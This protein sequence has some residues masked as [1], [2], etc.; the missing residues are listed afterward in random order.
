MAL[1]ELVT[2]LRYE[3]REGNL[4]KYVDGY[5]RAEG[6]INSAA[7]AATTKLNT[8]LN[9]SV[10]ATGRLERGTGRAS[11]AIGRMASKARQFGRDLGEGV[12]KGSR[13]ASAALDKLE[14]RASKLNGK[15]AG[16]AAATTLAAYAVLVR[17]TQNAARFNRENQL[18]GNTAEMNPAE[19]ASLRDTILNEARST[20]QN[21]DDLQAALGYLVAAGM[22]AG[23]AQASIRT[24]GRATTAAGADIQDMAQAAF[25]L[26][27]AL[28]ID[29]AGLQQAID[30]LAT[31][32]KEGNVELKDMARVLPVLGSQFQALKM[33][34]PE[35]A[36]T[37]AA[38]LEI[39][40]KGAA[41]ADEAATNLQNFLSKILSPE[42]LNKAEKVFN[43][44]LYKVVVDAQS[45]G[46]NPLE[47]A[48]EA[49]AKVTNGDQKKLGELFQDMQVQNFLRPMLQ[50]YSEYQRIKGVAL[51]QSSGTTD[52]DFAKMASTEAEQIKSVG[53]AVDNLSK[54]L[55]TA[56]EPAVTA[57]ARAVAPII[58]KLADWIDKNRGLA[59]AVA[60]SIVGVLALKTA[61]I[62]L[63]IASLAA[64][65][66]RILGGA[67]GGLPEATGAASK[68][69]G[70]FLA[71][72]GLVAGLSELAIAGLG[73]LGLPTPEEIAA[74][75]TGVGAENI[76]RGEWLKASANL[77]AA[78]FIKAAWDRVV[79]SYG[80]DQV[81]QML[82]NGTH[83]PGKGPSGNWVPP[84]AMNS[85]RGGWQMVPPTVH[86]N[87][88][89]HVT[90]PSGANPAAYGAAAQRGTSKAM[91]SFQYQLPTAVE[92]F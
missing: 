11:Y 81:A 7:K 8:A 51:H 71:K 27:D 44:D 31:A 89:V 32:G 2:V 16:S 76:R 67:I 56:L 63:Q 79:L 50:N 61:I 77:P 55:G 3:L 45:R 66:L 22:D 39:A 74:Q 34:G 75:G 6:Q 21:A 70:G 18:I 92:S 28:K 30:I 59:A 85:S 87:A 88:T 58:Q 65:R 78:D 60:L 24:I 72:L 91:T 35:A 41:S 84:G 68:G 83:G 9:G 26:Q 40:R 1:R 12:R 82:M 10:A 69:V 5:K 48:V 13:D 38:S 14:N 73:R 20:N 53:I 86:N 37:M 46:G 49:I 62:A 15:L 29:P 36:A 64:T 17:P 43:L 47:A 25:S 57:V 42:T 90:A 19:V 33:R 23:T 52:R 54:S 4:K 80:N